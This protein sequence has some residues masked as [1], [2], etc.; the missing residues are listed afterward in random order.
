MIRD[1]D[2]LA[3]MRRAGIVVAEM[4]E[5]TRD[6]I[7]PGVTTLSIDKVAREVLERRS[8]RSNFLNYRGFPAVIC[9]S[10]N[11]MIVHGIPGEYVL[12]EGDILSVDCGAIIEGYHGDAAYTA[13]VGAI[14][15]EAQRLLDVTERSLYAGIDQM[16]EGNRLHDIG[17]A[18]QEVAE[19]AGFSV[20]KNYVG[21]AIGTAM[22]EDPQVPNY[23]P[24]SPGPRLKVG[25]VYAI[26]PMV[27]VGT[28]KT[29]ELDDGWS[30]VT[31]DGSLSAHFE[32]TIAITENGPDILTR[33]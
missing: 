26:E 15:K 32:H 2:E 23:W 31:A 33:P 10:P 16:V 19:S 14:S 5:K 25:N 29:R 20:V 22:H 3:K 11:E 17:R 21:H 7:R 8:A 13:G 9:T 24:G 6:A 27:N 18:V 28:E 12:Q 30:V 1:K 4:H